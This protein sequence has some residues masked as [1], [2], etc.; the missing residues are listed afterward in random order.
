MKFHLYFP[1]GI[2]TAHG[3]LFVYGD[4]TR[5]CCEFFIVQAYD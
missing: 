2:F 3:S 4:L 5:I 1:A